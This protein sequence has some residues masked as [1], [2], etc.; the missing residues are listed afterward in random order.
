MTAGW[1]MLLRFLPQLLLWKKLF[2]RLK[3]NMLAKKKKKD[4]LV[5]LPFSSSPPLEGVAPLD[6]FYLSFADLCSW[7][8]LILLP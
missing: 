8:S 7:F 1:L 3:T 2:V 6:Y 5:A 4:D